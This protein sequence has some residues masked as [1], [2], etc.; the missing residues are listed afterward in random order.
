METLRGVT[1]VP[2][3]AIQ[4]SPKGTFVYQVKEDKTVAVRWVKTGAE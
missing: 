3:S 1:V 2:T 4:N